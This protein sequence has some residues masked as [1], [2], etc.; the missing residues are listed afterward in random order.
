MFE[1]QGKAR[2]TSCRRFFF[3]KKKSWEKKKERKIGIVGYVKR[4]SVPRPIVFCAVKK[5]TNG[6]SISSRCP[7]TSL[8][9]F[10][11]FLLFRL[12][13][14]AR[15]AV[16]RKARDGN[17]YVC[18]EWGKNRVSRISQPR[19]HCCLSSCRFSTHSCHLGGCNL[20]AGGLSPLRCIT[21]HT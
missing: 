18:M 3:H 17:G 2:Y 15:E 12:V 13:N 19:H 7:P 8:K 21:L 6:Q 14:E 5:A 20:P 16:R 9:L 1:I 10:P 11:F 4:N